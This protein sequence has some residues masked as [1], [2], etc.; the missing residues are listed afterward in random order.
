MHLKHCEIRYV[1]E[2]SIIIAPTYVEPA[3]R[4]G[5]EWARRHVVAKLCT[6]HILEQNVEKTAPILG[7][8]YPDAFHYI[9]RRALSSFLR[10]GLA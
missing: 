3:E 1:C 2:L 10:A 6:M 9:L 7:A 8:L 4:K 5:E